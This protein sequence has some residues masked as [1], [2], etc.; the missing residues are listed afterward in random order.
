MPTIRKIIYGIL[1]VALNLATPVYAFADVLG[2]RLSDLESSTDEVSFLQYIY[3]LA[4]PLAVFSL[5]G[6]SIYA[7]YLMITSQGNPDKLQEARETIVNAVL[8][9]AMVALSIALLA[10]L[11]GILNISF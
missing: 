3:Q 8:G 11:G 4:I 9:F 10:L 5:V 2:D 1:A 7:G 6:L